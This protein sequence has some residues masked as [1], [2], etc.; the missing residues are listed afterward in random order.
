VGQGGIGVAPGAKWIACRN[1][2]RGYGSV[3]SYMSCLQF[4]LAPTN[5][6]GN[7]PNPDVRPQ[8]IGNSYGCVAAEGCS[9]DEFTE[10]VEALRVAGVFMS[11]SAGNSGPACGTMIDPPATEESVISVG[12]TAVNSDAI[13]SYS[14][15]GPVGSRKAPSVVAPGSSVRSCT[16]GGGYASYSGTSMASPHVAGYVNLL[17]SVCPQLLFDVDMLQE[18]LQTTARTLYSTQGC[19]GDTS[20]TTPNNVFGHGIM[21]LMAAASMC[22]P[23][24]TH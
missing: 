17:T 10:A 14:S 11:V 9:G 4:F 12:A 16:P 3:A 2:D 15:R 22:N 6:Q 13:A 18:I 7:S 1:M 20:S 19:G 21:D 24:K 5:L 8:A 23:V